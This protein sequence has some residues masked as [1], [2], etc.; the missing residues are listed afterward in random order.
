MTI[1]E[2]RRKHGLSRQKVASDVGIS[3]S[4]LYAIEKGVFNPSFRV[5]DAIAAYFGV[6]VEEIFPQFRRRSPYPKDTVPAQR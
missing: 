2:F 3:I 4:T 1:Q 5:A 6:P